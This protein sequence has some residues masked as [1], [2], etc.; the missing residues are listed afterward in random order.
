MMEFLFGYAVG[1]SS[2]KKSAGG[3]YVFIAIMMMFGLSIILGLLYEFSPYRQELE[4]TSSDI[5]ENIE[6]SEYFNA[7]FTPLV[8][9]LFPLVL[10]GG[11]LYVLFILGYIIY[12]IRSE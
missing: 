1:S 7:S 8:E 2:S 9:D 11:I 6:K 10:F 3:G 12:R 4:E 5:L